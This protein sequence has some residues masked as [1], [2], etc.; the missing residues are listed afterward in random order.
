MQEN[1]FKSFL[2]ST[3]DCDISQQ[4]YTAF[5]ND[6]LIASG[7]KA[8]NLEAWAMMAGEKL[9]MWQP[10][11]YA[12]ASL[13]ESLAQKNL[14]DL[15]YEVPQEWLGKATQILQNSEKLQGRLNELS[16][17]VLL[18]LLLR[19][20]RAKAQGWSEVLQ[21]M[22]GIEGQLSY[23][24]T[25]VLILSRI[26]PDF[27]LFVT[28][29]FSTV[30]QKT[31]GE[32]TALAVH[33]NACTV[34]PLAHHLEYYRALFGGQAIAIQVA[35]LQALR[36]YYPD[37][38]IRNL[39]SSFLH[40]DEAA[41]GLPDVSSLEDSILPGKAAELKTQAKLFALAGK[42]SQAGTLLAVSSALLEEM[43]KRHLKY[44]QEELRYLAP[45][46]SEI[47]GR[48]LASIDNFRA[49]NPLQAEDPSPSAAYSPADM[50]A[51]LIA[52]SE[53]PENPKLLKDYAELLLKSGQTEEAVQAAQ[54]AVYL[55][56]NDPRLIIWFCNFPPR[57]AEIDENIQ[58]IFD[59]LKLKEQDISLHL[60][61]ASQF[62]AKGDAASASSALD[63]LLLQ[64]GLEP[65]ALYEC[66]TLYR[67]LSKNEAALNCFMRG[68]ESLERFSLETFLKYFYAFLELDKSPFARDL[69]QNYPSN[70][71]EQSSLQLAW[72]DLAIA[73]GQVSS[74][75]EQLLSIAIPE[76]DKTLSAEE[77]RHHLSRWGAYYRLARVEQ[78]LG[79]LESARRYANEAWKIDQVSAASF[80][81]NLELALAASDYKSFD[82]LYKLHAERALSAAQC[83]SLATL[84][85]LRTF[86][87]TWSLPEKTAAEEQ[88]LTNEK[89][90]PIFLLSERFMKIWEAAKSAVEAWFR[91]D[92]TS[93][94]AQ[95]RAA[96]ERVPENAVLNLLLMNYLSDSMVQR[97]N[98]QLLHVRQNL[99]ETY[100]ESG[101]DEKEINRQL[102][103]A[104]K[105][106]P[107]EVISPVLRLSQA[108][109]QGAWQRGSSLVNLVNTP[110]QAAMALS[111]TDEKQMVDQICRAYPQEPCVQ[112]QYALKLLPEQPAGAYKIGELLQ[113]SAQYEVLG[114]A[115]CAYAK[116]DKP[117]EAVEHLRAALAIWPDEADWHAQ[118]GVYLEQLGQFGEAAEQ[119]E[120]AIKADPE[121]A[122]Y[123][124]ILGNIKVDEKNFEAA[125]E[126]FNKAVQRFPENAKALENLALI[127]Q[128]M[129][130][131]EAAIASLKKA[132]ILEPGTARYREKLCQVYFERGDYQAAIDEANLILTNFEDSASALLVKISVYI[133]RKVFEEAEHLI[134]NSRNRFADPIPFEIAASEMEALTHKKKALAFTEDLLRKY[135][136][137]LRV[138]KNHAKY[139]LEF[140]YTAQAVETLQKCLYLKAQNPETLLLLGKAYASLKNHELAI[141]Y[142]NDALKHEPGMNDALIGMGEVYQE[143]QDL[144][145]AIA[146]YEKA[147]SLSD[148]DPKPYQLA[149]SVYREKKD[150]HRAES[151]LKEA[152][153][154]FP[155]DLN[156]K[157]QLAGM[158][159][160]NLVNNLQE[161]SKRK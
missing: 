156:L 38:N 79:S 148:T 114:H 18:A 13:D 34:M 11:L 32:V 12:L 123:W 16:E 26:V 44:Q 81:L 63:K 87:Q 65:E 91:K 25:P 106:L 86:A 55:G 52:L 60:A 8:E 9:R 54:K 133:K 112:F 117:K 28:E 103:L 84:K 160:I 1:E 98:M 19:D 144:E 78:T 150:Y 42:G 122:E 143:E 59:G 124:Q 31:L 27:D 41:F 3:F 76:K 61:L 145:K 75:H 67:S 49:M 93:A 43:L 147:L 80:L 154:K 77:S 129:H 152:I 110:W 157:G 101:N 95:F 33:A 6:A 131:Y 82:A 138:L 15:G 159:A 146:F 120:S 100:S 62:A 119:L 111:M 2:P 102:V 39:A 109:I 21:F 50:D 107:G 20:Y 92:W 17:A 90:E 141:K 68:A 128:Q 57:R 155:S 99:P 45:N 5:Q 125:K 85:W 14:R 158:M 105:Y 56:L 83:R 66:A 58:V 10:G 121:N 71:A 151:I 24:E 40:S 149:A 115:L 73:E 113:K 104:G 64:E 70:A 127:N 153:K 116:Q 136:N 139:Q 108:V 29:I 137:D 35:G 36:R 118:A 69:A 88:A 23:W 47:A 140:G 96:L 30:S 22:A 161:S 72:A 126:Y 134:A 74:A 97:R 94:N 48:Q 89:F 7:L 51:L 142:F 46:E 135:P 132:A 37:E 53:D 4:I 130:Q